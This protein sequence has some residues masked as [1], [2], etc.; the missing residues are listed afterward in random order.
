MRRKLARHQA[1]GLTRSTEQIIRKKMMNW[2][3]IGAIAELLGAIGVIGSLV[4]LAT[5]LKASTQASQIEAKFRLTDR[6]ADFG[7]MLINDPKLND[8]M[9]RGHK[10]PESLSREEYFVFSNLC[11]KAYWYLSGAY[12]MYNTESISRDDWHEFEVI[13]HYWTKNEGFHYWWKKIG[14]ASF[15]GVFKAYMEDLMQHKDLGERSPASSIGA[16]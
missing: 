13:A 11:Q 16:Q 14:H 12:F 4:Y 5:Q 8:I 15:S 3:A 9:L 10:N 7:D 1:L 2:D 6:M